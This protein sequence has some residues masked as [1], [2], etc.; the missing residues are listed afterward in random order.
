M[1]NS[2]DNMKIIYS[3]TTIPDF[4]ISEYMPLLNDNQVKV[5]LY[6]CFLDK[7]K[8]VFNEIVLSHIFKLP[9]EKIIEILYS[10]IDA[11]LIIKKNTTFYL[12]D[13]KE[14]ALKKLYKPITSPTIDA[15]DEKKDII[16][17][18]NKNFFQSV[19][20]IAWYTTIET[21]FTLYKFDDDVMYSLFSY[22]FNKDT[23]S[24]AYVETVAKNWSENGVKNNFDLESY[25]DRYKNIKI[26]AKKVA[27]K[28]N[29]KTPLTQYEEKY[30][31][32]WTKQYKFSFEIIDIALKNTTKISNPNLE[33]VHKILTTW[34]EKGYKTREDIDLGNKKF[35]NKQNSSGPTKGMTTK[36]YYENIRLENKA[37]LEKRKQKVYI[38]IPLYKQLEDDIVEL[39]IKVFSLNNEKKQDI[40]QKIKLKESNKMTLLVK[41][42]YDKDYLNP[43]YTCQK[44]ED[45]GLLP[46]GKPCNCKKNI[47]K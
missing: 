10:L 21:L 16:S 3:D 30:I 15:L 33:Y 38:D 12:V 27:R 34:H 29:R 18:I 35:L 31:E 32:K 43:I 36:K 26:L 4:F 41:S 25:F 44:C 22:C 20:A 47:S 14:V 40:L 37:T 42:G 17:A 6:C 28:L 8:K 11:G 46:T 1:Q 23:L 24:K 19:M 45:T 13:I 9:Q 5:Y 39:S 7:Y 2:K